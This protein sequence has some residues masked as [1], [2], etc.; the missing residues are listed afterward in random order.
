MVSH[1]G[2]LNEQLWNLFRDTY[3]FKL[4]ISTIYAVWVP[5]SIDKVWDFVVVE[6]VKRLDDCNSKT[7]GHINRMAKP[8]LGNIRVTSYSFRNRTHCSFLHN[9]R[10]TMKG[11][12]KIPARTKSPGQGCKMMQYPGW[13][14]AI[15][16][17]AVALKSCDD[18]STGPGSVGLF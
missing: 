3:K 2:G 6:T 17:I 10:A 14:Y 1:V 8:C 12:I 4:T 13:S 9:K 5:S 7:K 18:S 11:C 15:H 16:E